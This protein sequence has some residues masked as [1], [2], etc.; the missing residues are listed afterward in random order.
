MEQM[1]EMKE[2]LSR[3]REPIPDWLRRYKSGDRVCFKDFIGGRVGYYPGSRFDGA[4][5]AVCNR[6]H[7]VHSFLYV[8]YGL[9]REILEDLAPSVVI[10]DYDTKKRCEKYAFTREMTPYC[11]MDIYERNADNGDDWGTE[12][13]AVTSLFADGI[14]TYKQLFVREYCK[15]PWTFLL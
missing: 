6:S 10:T 14:V 15:A 13:F 1:V 5:I 9:K 4:L 8:D 11:F 12:R 3:F 7:C 2:F